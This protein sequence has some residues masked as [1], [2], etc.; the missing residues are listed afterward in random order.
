[1]K[2]RTSQSPDEYRIPS[3]AP[4]GTVEFAPELET[5]EERID[6]HM[7]KLDRMRRDAEALADSLHSA[8]PNN[9]DTRRV[10]FGG[11]VIDAAAR[12]AGSEP[13]RDMTHPDMLLAHGASINAL[14][15]A[16][17]EESNNSKAA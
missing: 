17:L 13:E 3:F 14:R 6:L 4:D 16:K 2:P 11:T 10:E 5:G 9:I 15:R 1:M 12:F 8:D 7:S